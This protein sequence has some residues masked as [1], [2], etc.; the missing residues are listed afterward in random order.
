[1]ARG[2]QKM[3]AVRRD[4][5]ALKVPD[6]TPVTL[7]RDTFV[8]ITQDMGG[9]FTVTANGQM[10]RIDGT[11]ADAIGQQP[12]KLE[13]DPPE[14][15]GSI[16]EEDLWKALRTIFDPEIPVNVVDLGLIY[17]CDVIRRNGERVV[18]VRMTL[19]SPACG[20]GPVLVGDVEKRLSMVPNVDSVEVSLEF[21]PP[22]D[23]DMMSDEARL[24]LGLY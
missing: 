24:E 13:F 6:G 7:H 5:P 23:R 1:M 15:D 17:G 19:T 10:L 4:V 2:E 22:W 12:M 16:R 3:V 20:M 21:D 18:Q 14:P 11:D 8:N 9:N